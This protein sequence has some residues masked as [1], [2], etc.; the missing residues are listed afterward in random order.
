MLNSIKLNNN[1]TILA[2]REKGY[3][4]YIVIANNEEDKS[5]ATFS[6]AVSSF[7]NIIEVSPV[8]AV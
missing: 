1:V 7:G 8:E 6:F 4:E 3:V 2:E 5:T